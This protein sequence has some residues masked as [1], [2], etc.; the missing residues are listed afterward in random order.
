[1]S[2]SNCSLLLRGGGSATGDLSG[3]SNRQFV[4]KEGE[5]RRYKKT[6]QGI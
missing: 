1:L 5:R 4:M 3:V 6:A 2:A